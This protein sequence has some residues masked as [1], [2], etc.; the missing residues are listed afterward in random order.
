VYRSETAEDAVDWAPY[1]QEALDVMLKELNETG[2][3]EQGGLVIFNHPH[4]D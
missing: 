2:R 4:W 1:S 3:A